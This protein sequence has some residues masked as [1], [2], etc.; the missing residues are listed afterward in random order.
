MEPHQS[1]MCDHELAFCVT[2]RGSRHSHSRF[3]L[4]GA[5]IIPAQ[6]GASVR[7]KHRIDITEAIAQSCNVYTRMLPGWARFHAMSSG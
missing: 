2:F 6:S 3:V 1:H 5:R 4:R 7:R